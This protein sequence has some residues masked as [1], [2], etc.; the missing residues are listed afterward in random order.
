[1]ATGLG[2]TERKTKYV[3]LPII[4]YDQRFANQAASQQACGL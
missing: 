4:R 1:M 2:M 3:S